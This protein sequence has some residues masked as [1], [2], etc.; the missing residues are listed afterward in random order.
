[1]NPLEFAGKVSPLLDHLSNPFRLAILL[2]IGDGEA[3][4]CHLEAVLKKRQAYISQ[5]LAGLRE[6]G[7]LLSRREGRFVYYRLA[8]PAWLD[9]IRTA[10]RLAGADLTPP[11]ATVKCLCPDCSDSKPGFIPLNV[12]I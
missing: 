3:C 2:S 7:M 11:K 6:A 1:M 10:G 5:H 9:L 8:D 4:V 12:K